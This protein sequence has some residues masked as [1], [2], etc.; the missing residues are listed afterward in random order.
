MRRRYLPATGDVR[1]E[2]LL[3]QGFLILASLALLALLVFTLTVHPVTI[4]GGDTPWPGTISL[5]FV[6][7]HYI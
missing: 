4:A 2:R 1:R 6:S 5:Q 3:I 7:S